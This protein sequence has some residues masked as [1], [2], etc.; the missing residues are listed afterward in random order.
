[1]CIFSKKKKHRYYI[2]LIENVFY[3]TYK[4]LKMYQKVLDNIKE[5]P[6]FKL[7]CKKKVKLIKI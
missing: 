3:Y 7:L 2:I 1:M 6:E 4:K 5:L